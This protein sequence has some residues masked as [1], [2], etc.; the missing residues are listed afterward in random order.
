MTV[1]YVVEGRRYTGNVLFVTVR[2]LTVRLFSSTTTLYSTHLDARCP[3]GDLPCGDRPQLMDT[4]SVAARIL[5]RD[6]CLEH[7]VE[8]VPVEAVQ[9]PRGCI[10]KFTN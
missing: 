1:K 10:E 6:V 2:R 8:Q 3:D 7:F 4:R 5:V 9:H